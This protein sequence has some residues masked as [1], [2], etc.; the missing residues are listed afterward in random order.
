MAGD[1][2]GGSRLVRLVVADDLEEV[3]EFLLKDKFIT[4]VRGE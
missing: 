3:L 2:S 4:S 1:K